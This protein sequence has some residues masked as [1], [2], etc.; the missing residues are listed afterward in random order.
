MF[1]TFHVPLVDNCDDLLALGVVDVDEE[2]L[3]TLVY[4]DLLHAGEVDINSLNVPVDKVGV[5]AFLSKCS[6][7][8]LSDLLSISFIF[9][10]PERK[11]VL[12]SAT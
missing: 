8:S 1:D 9:S 4:E 5:K 2:V 6:W 3:V 11:G 10:S 7:A 12:E